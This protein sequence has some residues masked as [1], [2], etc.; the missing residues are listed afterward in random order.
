MNNEGAVKRGE[1]RSKR[2]KEKEARKRKEE[3]N[4][5]E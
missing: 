5:K 1:R 3:S 2:E 4:Q